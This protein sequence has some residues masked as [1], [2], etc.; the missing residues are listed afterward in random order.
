MRAIDLQT[1]VDV[2]KAQ[3]LSNHQTDFSGI[4]TDTRS[5]LK[6]QLF[7]ALKGEA[8]DAHNFLDKAVEQGATGLLVHDRSVVTAG[9][10]EKATVFLVEDTLKALQELG[11][12]ARHQTRAK[13]IGITGSN[14]KTTTKEFAAA[15]LSSVFDVHFNK[16]SFN[17]HWGV[18]FTLLQTPVNKDVAIVEMGMNHAGE[19]TELSR[20]VEPDVVVCTMVGRAHME[21]FG[22]I[23][24][25]A[26]AKEEIY[27]SAPKNA[28]LIFNLDNAQTFRMYEKAIKGRDEKSV[29][30]FSETKTADVQLEITEVTLSS[31]TIE[32]EISGVQCQAK[33]D[34]FG[35]QNL[36]NLMAAAAIGL[37][38]GMTADQV[39]AGLP[40]CRT[41][42]GRNQVLES[43][44]GAKVI[45]D[46]Y[47]A[48]PD[49]MK[50]LIENM[51]RVKV[52]G[53]KI[54]VFGQMREM[55]ELSASLHH[56]LGQWVGAA[57]FA[58]V[59]FIGADC[60]AF[61]RGVQESSYRGNLNVEVDFT[62]GIGTQLRESLAAGDL[63]CL[64][65]SRGTKLER[66]V[67][68]AGVVDFQAKG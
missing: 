63:I 28:K 58:E 17:N 62:D 53:K 65:A 16:G 68:Y 54:G 18:P 35:V 48:N 31:L 47:N 1:I 34:V 24:K 45:F 13:I 5:D 2:T 60:E 49:S 14:G 41:I 67:P 11:N 30:T 4:G 33:V 37:A 42:W 3:L 57:D 61:K 59:F 7:I 39:W 22:T 10:K 15:V 25:V 27:L 40:R 36:T 55:G 26:E 20:I 32:G 29:I 44:V 12:W 23:E 64:K 19:L 52:A 66:F 50:A 56:E 51:K 46:A 6:G 9:L 43:T 38:S 21:F 8:F